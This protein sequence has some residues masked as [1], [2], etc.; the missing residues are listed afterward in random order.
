MQDYKH[1]EL[2]LFRLTCPK[3]GKKSDEVIG[4]LAGKASIACPGCRAP[5]DL[6]GHEGAIDKL[7]D[8]ATQLD[9]LAHQRK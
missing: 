5:I 1:S 4:N 3:C 9:A 2:I 7:M 6:K 8:T